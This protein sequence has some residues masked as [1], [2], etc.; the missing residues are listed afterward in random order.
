MLAGKSDKSSSLPFPSIWS[1]LSSVTFEPAAASSDSASESLFS[2]QGKARGRLRGLVGSLLGV[3]AI[4]ASSAGFGECLWVGCLFALS[5]AVVLNC[6]G[7][8]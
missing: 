1:L 8:R 4:S 2:L 3:S 6:F 7:K 5:D